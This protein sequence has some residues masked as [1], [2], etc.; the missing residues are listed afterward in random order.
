MSERKQFLKLFKLKLND[1]I[2]GEI[3][4]YA[5]LAKT[6]R[7]ARQIAGKDSGMMHWT[8]ENLS[9]CSEVFLD[10]SPQVIIGSFWGE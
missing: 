10:A 4:E 7:Q 3:H 9:T 6:V 2:Y 8:D 1:A 5:V